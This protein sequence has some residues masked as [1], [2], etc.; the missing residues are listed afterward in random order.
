MD[1]Y[2]KGRR[3]DPHRGQ[4]YFSSLPGVDIL[5]TLEKFHYSSKTFTFF[6]NILI[7]ICFIQSQIAYSR[8][9]SFRCVLTE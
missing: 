1:Q 5:N 2:S 4:A 3:F 6:D 7:E 8:V 9:S